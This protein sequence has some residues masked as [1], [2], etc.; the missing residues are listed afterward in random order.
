MALAKKYYETEWRGNQERN[1][2]FVAMPQDEKAGNYVDFKNRFDALKSLADGL[3]IPVVLSGF[4]PNDGTIMDKIFDYLANSKFLIFDLSNDSRYNSPN[5]NVMY[6]LGIAVTIRQP[7]DIIILKANNKSNSELWLP[8]DVKDIHVIDAD[9]ASKMVEE[10][11][12]AIENQQKARNRLISKVSKTLD[13]GCLWLMKNYG[14]EPHGFSHMNSQT[15]Q[16]QCPELLRPLIHASLSKLLELG[17]VETNTAVDQQKDWLEYAYWWTPFS[18]R[19][20][21]V[22][23]VMRMKEPSEEAKLRNQNFDKT[24]SE[25]FQQ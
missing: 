9:I 19:V 12:I 25:R 2:I 14:T 23:G 1:E 20:M 16:E 21:E 15:I 7:E 8:F 3:K 4:P 18:E 6:E 24:K 10:I 11:K 22:I 13:H 5:P 17:L